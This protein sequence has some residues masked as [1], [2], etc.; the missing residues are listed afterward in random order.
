MS[1]RDIYVGKSGIEGEG[2]FAR[3]NFKKGETVFVMKGKRHRHVNKDLVDTEA[4]PN[5]VGISKNMWIDPADKFQ[6]INHSC[7]PNMGI[8]GKVTY[9]ALRDIKKGEEL[10]FD[11]S[12][13]EEDERWELRNLEKKGSFFRPKIRSI[14]SLPESVFK[15]YLPYIPTYFQT[16]YYRSHKGLKR[17]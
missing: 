9:V 7:N 13:T 3:K 11:Y 4:H 15:R 6:Y 8:L 12:I 10:V 5:W 1:A 2:V 14:Q 17:S 16:V